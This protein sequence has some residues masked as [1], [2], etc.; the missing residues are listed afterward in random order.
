[1]NQEGF[2]FKNFS[3]DETFNLVLGGRYL[4]T[5]HATWGIGTLALQ[6]LAADG[7]P[8]S[9]LLSTQGGSDTA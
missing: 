9:I 4:L 3:A 1:M 8:R 2:P 5:A 7:L 6:A